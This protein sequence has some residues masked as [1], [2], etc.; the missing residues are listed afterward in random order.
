[1]IE[2]GVAPRPA[3][4]FVAAGEA[5]VGQ[6]W[7]PTDRRSACGT[8]FEAWAMNEYR[9]SKKTQ[10]K[11]LSGAASSSTSVGLAR[12]RHEHRLQR[13][14]VVSMNGADDS[15][16]ELLKRRPIRV[17]SRYLQDR[18]LFFVG[19]RIGKSVA[20]RRDPQRGDVHFRRDFDTPPTR[21]TIINCCALQNDDCP[22]ANR[23]VT[24]R[25]QPV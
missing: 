20:V 3:A 8:S 23:I 6:F 11:S 7:V 19:A 12:L 9:E 10:S 16:R 4:N 5:D 14:P 13:F 17:A 24:D 15:L 18:Y 22:L 1:M 25:R 2:F 21:A